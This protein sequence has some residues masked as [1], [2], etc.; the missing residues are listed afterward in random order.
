MKRF[1]KNTLIAL[2]AVV[3]AVGFTGCSKQGQPR[4]RRQ[5]FQV[6]SLDKVSGSMGEQW[7][8]T[9]TVA[10]NTASNMRITAASAF[11][12]HNGRKIGRLVLDGEVVL[13]RRR[14]SQ[15]EVPLRLTLSNPIGA[16][17]LMNRLRKGDFS[18]VTVD[19]SVSVAAL[20][21]HRIFEQEGVALDQLARQF[22]LGLKK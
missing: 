16:L 19:Y 1:I 21:S 5:K 20:M 13:P 14:C 4:Q 18:G 6:V 9:L 7:R 10:N 11:V 8:V 2:V 12:R 22:N 3:V 15:V 17:A